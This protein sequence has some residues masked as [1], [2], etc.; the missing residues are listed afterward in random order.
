MPPESQIVMSESTPLVMAPFAVEEQ[1]AWHGV[2][3]DEMS[4]GQRLRSVR[5]ACG[6]T[7]EQ[8]ALACGFSGQSRIANYEAATGGR[9]PSIEDLN[10]LARALRVPVGVL[11]DPAEFAV[12]QRSPD[13]AARGAAEVAYRYI[14]ADDAGRRMIEAVA[15]AAEQYMAKAS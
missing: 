2:R 1:H 13:A 4:F 5:R 12:W 10:T 7:Q 11:V 8:L 9:E 14:H 6:L 15:Q 3:V